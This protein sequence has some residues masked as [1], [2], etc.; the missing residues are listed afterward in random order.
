MFI[1]CILVL[2]KAHRLRWMHFER[3][4]WQWT[5]LEGHGSPVWCASWRE[6]YL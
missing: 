1:T 3:F 5:Y 2:L 4:C 6:E